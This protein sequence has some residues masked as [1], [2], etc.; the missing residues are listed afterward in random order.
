MILLVYVVP[1]FA[2]MFEDMNVEMPLITK[3]VLAVGST[4]Q[5]FWWL[6]IIGIVLGAGWLRRQMGE[7]ESRLRID[8]RLLRIAPEEARDAA[9]RLHERRV[10]RVAE[11]LDRP[12][13]VLAVGVGE[14]HLDELVVRERAVELL[15]ERRSHALLAD[16]DDGI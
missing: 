11:R 8:A 2:P 4:L 10:R 16:H 5:S 12:G 3:I 9:D 6:I 14:L 1:Q 13:A 15:Q 7:P